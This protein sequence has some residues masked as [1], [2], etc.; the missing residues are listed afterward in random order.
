[1]RKRFFNHY[2]Q[3][4]L[5]MLAGAASILLASCGGFDGA[6]IPDDRRLALSAGQEQQG[7][8]ETRD[9]RFEYQVTMNGD[10][11]HLK[12]TL[13]VRKHALDRFV[14]NIFFANEAGNVIGSNPVATAIQG[15]E[16]TFATDVNVPAG[17]TSISFGY[18]GEYTR[19]EMGTSS[20]WYYP[21]TQQ[22]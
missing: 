7:L 8:L 17:T 10:L 1:M 2:Q 5:A 21:F 18:N 19:T 4:V 22:P 3:W 11:L 9:I 13:L 14:L 16:R 12:G 15:G 20:F 6:F